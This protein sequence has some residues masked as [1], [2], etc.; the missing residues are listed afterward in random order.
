MT[1]SHRIKALCAIVI[2]FV[3]YSSHAALI[4]KLDGQVVYDDDR[5]ITWV[6]DAN[7]AASNTFGLPTGILL[8]THPDN[9]AFPDMEGYIY[10]SGRMNWAAALHFIDAMNAANYLGFND[11]RLPW[12]LLPDSSCSN[13]GST[14]DSTGFDCTG[15]EMGHLFYEEFDAE[16][17]TSVLD[18]GDPAEL[19]KFSNLTRSGYFADAEFGAWLFHFWGG[20]QGNP[21]TVDE[22]KQLFAWPVRDGDV[23]GSAAD[24]DIDATGL[25]DISGDAVPDVA[26]LSQLA[27]KRTAR[28]SPRSPT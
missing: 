21:L 12:T 1:N 8:G 19:A 4:P 13:F 11:W 15:S 28:N 24:S 23:G 18:T 16:R 3:T 22:F 27:G 2:S 20:A 14:G 17:D 26:V 25:T 6:A 10:P 9:A 5:D 7:L